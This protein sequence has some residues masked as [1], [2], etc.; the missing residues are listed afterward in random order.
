VLGG[1]V[2][3]AGVASLSHRFANVGP[4]TASQFAALQLVCMVAV[5]VILLATFGRPVRSDP[6]ARAD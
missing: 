5:V 2:A 1:L 4:R 6:G 3:V